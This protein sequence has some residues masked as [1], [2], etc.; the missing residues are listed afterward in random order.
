MGL[1]DEDPKPYRETVRVKRS[2]RDR[3][4][5]QADRATVERADQRTDP[6][7]ATEIADKAAAVADRASDVLHDAGDAA[8]DTATQVADKAASL[9][10]K[11]AARLHDI[12][13][14]Q[15]DRD[16]YLLG[17]AAVAVAAAVGIALQ[18]RAQIRPPSARH[19]LS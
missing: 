11:P 13:P 15:Q 14:D 3:G 5:R 12:I 16:T 1:H 7:G 8:R 10:R 2:G 19:P 17:A 9:A 4:R 6:Q 18:R